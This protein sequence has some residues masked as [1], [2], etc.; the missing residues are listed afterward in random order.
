MDWESKMVVAQTYVEY[1][2]LMGPNRA[3]PYLIKKET[4]VFMSYAEIMHIEL[5]SGHA[6]DVVE[7]V[8]QEH[9]VDLVVALRHIY[10][11]IVDDVTKKTPIYKPAGPK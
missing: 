9:N 5:E 7:K 4:G 1:V 10:G 3:H 2:Q 6:Y 8:M 11:P